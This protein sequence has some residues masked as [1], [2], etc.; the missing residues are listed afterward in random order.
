MTAYIYSCFSKSL[1]SGPSGNPSGNLPDA[2][3]MRLLSGLRT[4]LPT[5]L[6]TGLRSYLLRI[7]DRITDWDYGSTYS[8]TLIRRRI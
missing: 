1:Y 3:G 5:G 4:G 6:R 7:T 8:P 2:S